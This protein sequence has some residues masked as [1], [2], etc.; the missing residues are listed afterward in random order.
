[1]IYLIIVRMLF[2]IFAENKSS[3]SCKGESFLRHLPYLLFVLIAPGNFKTMSATEFFG[4]N[5][6]A[7]FK[8]TKSP[9][10]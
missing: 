5:D 9:A 6:L 3:R 8:R 2:G 4:F 10:F 1:M 7:F